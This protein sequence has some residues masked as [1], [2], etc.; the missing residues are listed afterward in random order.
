MMAQVLSRRDAPIRESGFNY[1]AGASA[2][3][4]GAARMCMKL[5]P[6]PPDAIARA[7]YH[8]GIETIAYMLEGECLVHCGPDLENSVMVRTG[9]QCFVAAD[10][11]HAPHTM[12][13]NPCTWIVAHSSGSDQVGIVLLPDLDVQLPAS[14]GKE[15]WSN[16]KQKASDSGVPV[17]GKSPASP[18]KGSPSRAVIS[19]LEFNHAWRHP[20][21]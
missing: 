20:E 18:V 2:E 5:L 10:V 17:F 14:V 3:M 19:H 16:A 8:E 13:E 4:V 15:T 21:M 12:S 7:H 6:M 1:G 9:E 11:P